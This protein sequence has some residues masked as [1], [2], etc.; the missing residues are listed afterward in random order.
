MAITGIQPPQGSGPQLIDGTWLNGLAGGLNNSFIN[1]VVAHAG[2]TK[3]A[4]FQIPAACKIVWVETVTTTGDSVLL[5]A[6]QTR[7][8]LMVYNGGAQ[9]LNLYGRGTDT[10]NG[11]ATATAYTLTAGQS[12]IFFC[13]KT[14]QWAAN[15]TS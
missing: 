11:V 15:K 14:G 8:M 5:P 13:G 9:S 2:D 7:N 4:A 6:A 3:A 10:I 12:A 1:G